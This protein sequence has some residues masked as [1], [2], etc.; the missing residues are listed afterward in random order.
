MQKKKN[1]KIVGFQV[2]VFIFLF[3][4]FFFFNKEEEGKREL[5]KWSWSDNN[6]HDTDSSTTGPLP[7]SPATP[8]GMKKPPA[9]PLALIARDR[10]EDKSFFHIIHRL[11]YV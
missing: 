9:L 2:T 4:N 6:L 1:S 10:D 11:L 8:E 7:R 5:G 3:S